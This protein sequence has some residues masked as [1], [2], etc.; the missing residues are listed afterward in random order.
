MTRYILGFV[1]SPVYKVPELVVCGHGLI[2]IHMTSRHQDLQLYATVFDYSNQLRIHPTL[3]RATYYATSVLVWGAAFVF[4]CN[5]PDWALAPHRVAWSVVSNPWILLVAAVLAISWFIRPLRNQLVQAG[6]NIQAALAASASVFDATSTVTGTAFRWLTKSFSRLV[7][8]RRQYLTNTIILDRAPVGS[9]LYSHAPLGDASRQIRLLRVRSGIF[10]VRCDLLAR[11][12]SW[13]SLPEYSAISWRWETLGTHTLDVNGR[14]F[15]IGQTLFD[16]LRDLVPLYGTAYF[17]I[18]A[19]CIDQGNT[20]EKELQIPQMTA[21]YSNAKRVIACLGHEENPTELL[22]FIGELD[23]YLFRRANRAA[24]PDLDRS[25]HFPFPEEVTKWRRFQRLLEHEFWTRAWIIQE[26]VV[27]RSVKILYGSRLMPWELFSR[28]VICFKSNDDQGVRVLLMRGVEPRRIKACN[29]GI[30]FISRL[31]YLQAKRQSGELGD[32]SLAALLVECCQ[33]QATNPL[34]KVYALQGLDENYANAGADELKPKYERTTKELYSNV[35]KYFLGRNNF[36]LLGLAGAVHT[37]GGFG[38]AAGRGTWVPDLSS[39]PTEHLYPLDN[40]TT[41]YRAGGSMAPEMRSPPDAAGLTL[42]I[43]GI[44]LDQICDVYE[45]DPWR[46]LQDATNGSGASTLETLAGREWSEEVKEYL[47]LQL[48]DWVQGIFVLTS[49]RLAEAGRELAGP[50]PMAHGQSKTEAILRTIICDQDGSSRRPVSSSPS[51]P[52]ARLQQQH[53][54]QRRGNREEFA[55]VPA[56]DAVVRGLHAALAGLDLGPGGGSVLADLGWPAGSDEDE[57]DDRRAA[58]LVAALLG[59]TMP[60]GAT[61]PTE[62]ALHMAAKLAS[63]RVF[64]LLGRASMGRRFALTR[65]CLAA[66]VPAAARAGDVVAVL[67]GARVPYVLR[68]AA[69][70]GDGGDGWE[71]VGEAFV[72]GVMGGEAFLARGREDMTWITLV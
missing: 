70:G 27:A 59:G 49:A 32:L 26:I 25:E 52:D 23:L 56:A 11:S 65:R 71:L 36:T 41:S 66:M 58:R 2:S 13:W 29:Y 38:S 19:I 14:D 46:T 44:V 17:W 35:V 64:G 50:F 1:V 62:R 54:Q 21:I 34:D 55:F 61:P 8:Q 47:V 39:L 3:R 60:A 9:C 22:D 5:R 16:A 30:D 20:A 42:Q 12:R 48:R 15:G 45:R 7:D 57:D 69:S 51:R 18:D 40:P 28:I 24:F 4:V 67:G 6:R 37:V 68:R 63:Q 31:R 33:S 43:K 53:K 10:V 72:H